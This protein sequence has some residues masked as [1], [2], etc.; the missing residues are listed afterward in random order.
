MFFTKLL[1]QMIGYALHWAP[2]PLSPFGRSR[3]AGRPAFFAFFAPQNVSRTFSPKP[4]G[5]PAGRLAGRPASLGSWDPKTCLIALK[6]NPNTIAHKRIPNTPNKVGGT[7]PR[8]DSRLDG[9]RLWP[10]QLNPSFANYNLCFVWFRPVRPNG[11]RNMMPKRWF[12]QSGEAF[13]N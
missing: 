2:P 5:R 6:R 7:S 10:H 8:I 11:D 9:I 3:P 13:L 4:A 12:E 1:S